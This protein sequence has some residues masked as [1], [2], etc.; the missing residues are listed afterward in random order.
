MDLTQYTMVEGCLEGRGGHINN[1][2]GQFSEDIRSI[3]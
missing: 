1:R 2:H 3:M